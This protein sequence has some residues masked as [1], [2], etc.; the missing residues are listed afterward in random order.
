MLGGIL[1]VINPKDTDVS[2]L[3]PSPGEAHIEAPRRCTAVKGGHIKVF[4]SCEAPAIT[5]GPL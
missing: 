4:L 3:H 1:T 2:G 5:K